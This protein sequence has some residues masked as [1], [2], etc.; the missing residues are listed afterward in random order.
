MRCIGQG[1]EFG[2]EVGIYSGLL[3]VELF[4]LSLEVGSAGFFGFRFVA[5]ALFEEHAYLLGDGVL[6]G[7]DGVGFLLQ[8][9][10]VGVE[11]DDF[12]DA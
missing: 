3:V 5:L 12:G 9:A 1:D 7:L 4:L 10:A 8:G 6:L 11:T 2:V